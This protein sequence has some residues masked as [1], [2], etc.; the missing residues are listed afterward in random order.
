MVRSSLWLWL[1][2]ALSLL[3]VPAVAQPPEVE[4][5]MGKPRHDGPGWLTW[6]GFTRSE[7]GPRVF[8]RLSSPPQGSVGQARA[9]DDLV[10][11]LPGYKLDG[12]NFGRPLD[13]R[14]FGT[15]VV[16]VS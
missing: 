16:R 2:C 3:A 15:D 6:V 13:T 1:S 8:V 9:G 7:T 5:A 12:R 4:P 11:T 10:V 14:Y